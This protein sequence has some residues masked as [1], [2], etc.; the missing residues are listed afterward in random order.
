LGKKT[1]L[2]WLTN[3]LRVD[4]NTLLDNALEQVSELVC[5]Y[6][7]PES[8]HFLKHYAQERQLGCAKH[9]FLQQSVDDLAKRLEEKGITLLVYEYA[10]RESLLTA[11]DQVK[12]T[13]LFCSYSAGHDEQII[14]HMIKSQFKELSVVQYGNSSLFQEGD[15]P[16]DLEAL[17]VT[18][19]RFRKQIEAQIEPSKLS[20]ILPATSHQITK[21]TAL[22]DLEHVYFRGGESE[23]LAHCERYFSSEL[24][25]TYKQTRNGLEGLAYSTKLSPWLAV[26]CVSPLRVYSFLKQYEERNGENDSTYWIYFELLWREYFYWYGRKHKCRLF[27]FDG[28]TG[29]KPLTTFYPQRFKQWKEGR[30]AF[31]IVN[32]C[33]NQ[34]RETGYLSNRGRQLA[35]SCLIHELGIDWRYGAAY[36]ETQLL[37]YDVGSNWGNWQYLAGVGADINGSRQFNLQK[38]TELYDPEGAFI[39][40]WCGAVAC[41]PTDL[42]D[43]V[44]WPIVITQVDK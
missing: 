43:M 37:D 4:D 3:D 1:G 41:G 8:T 21:L 24:P 10:L 31:P 13:H 2:Y 34:L 16:F 5:I 35:E 6:V 42:V 36:F 25:S 39:S 19:T 26:G 28:L 32:A 7:Y 15:L 14:T 33:M 9:R 44:D 20:P 18:F 29:N 12:P 23:G 11:I 38:Q 30:T 17:P 22:D 40:R 27:Q